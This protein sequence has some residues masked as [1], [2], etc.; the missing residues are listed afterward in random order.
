MTPAELRDPADLSVTPRVCG[1][2]L[3]GAR[4][5]NARER[6]AEKCIEDGDGNLLFSCAPT[7]CFCAARPVR[8]PLPAA[9]HPFRGRVFRHLLR[10]SSLSQ[11]HRMAD[12]PVPERKPT[13]HL[14]WARSESKGAAPPP[15]P[16]SAEEAKQLAA[17]SST[18]GG[19]AW[20]K[21]GNTWEEKRINTWAHELLKETLLPELS[22]EL[23]GAAGAVPKLPSGQE[24]DG[25]EPRVTVRVTA[26]DSVTGECTYVLSRG[27]QRVVFELTMKLVLEVELHIGGELKQILSGKLTLPELSND[28]LDDAKLPGGG[29]CLCALPLPHANARPKVPGTLPGPCSCAPI[30]LVIRLFRLMCRG[31]SCVGCRCDQ[32]GWK[33]FFEAAAKSCWVPLKGSLG[34]LIE[35]AKQKWA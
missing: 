21:G 12:I 26:V 13:D 33:P 20:N 28:D 22:Y 34:A 35:Q 14:Y 24:G 8:T 32:D 5:P 10:L 19:S 23:P 27:K 2:V 16:I 7:Y 30:D 4:A 1:G 31:L 9:A 3:C 6:L 15:K 25:G 11:L 29:K 17:A 18:A